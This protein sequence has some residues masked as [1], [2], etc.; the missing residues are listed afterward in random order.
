MIQAKITKIGN[1][2]GVRIPKALL[3]EGNISGDVTL[4]LRNGELIIKPVPKVKVKSRK[5]WAK[6]I[7][8]EIAKNGPFDNSLL[9]DWDV[10]VADGLDTL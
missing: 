5:G 8:D 6:M 2:Q 9:A 7:D 10:T 4:T 3:E 1:S